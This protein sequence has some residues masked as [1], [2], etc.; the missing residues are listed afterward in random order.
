MKILKKSLLYYI[1]E[2]LP[3]SKVIFLFISDHAIIDLK[4]N[5][6]RTALFCGWFLGILFHFLKAYIYQK[7]ASLYEKD[8]TVELLLNSNAN[9]DIENKYFEIALHKGLYKSNFNLNKTID[10]NKYS[11]VSKG[12]S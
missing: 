12:K 5:D 9:T 7:I 4:D 3:R 2:K 10:Q 8:K 6:G 1:K 11:S